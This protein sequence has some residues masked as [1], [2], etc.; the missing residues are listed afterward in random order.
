MAPGALGTRTKQETDASAQLQ[1]DILLSPALGGRQAFAKRKADDLRT[2]LY[3]F[4]SFCRGIWCGPVLAVGELQGETT[5]LQWVPSRVASWWHRGSWWRQLEVRQLSSVAPAFS[6][7]MRLW[8]RGLWREPLKNC[9]HWYVEA[10]SNAGGLEGGIILIHTALALLS[11]LVMVEDPRTRAYSEKKFDSFSAGDRI[12]HLLTTL[13][14]PCG[15]P[16][17]ELPE[18]AAALPGLGARDGVGAIVAIRND[19]VHPRRKR[20][21]HLLRTGS[22][23]RIE[24]LTLGLSLLET[25]LLRLFGF[26][27]RL[28]APVSRRY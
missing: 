2:A 21:T 23:G 16:A 11:W 10:N 17:G 22:S 14:M 27:G 9:L 8:N 12:R 28:A 3:Y 13:R 6:G 5:W 7:F 20:R 4:F 18:L 26:R 24:A 15:V 1:D 19:V 25:A